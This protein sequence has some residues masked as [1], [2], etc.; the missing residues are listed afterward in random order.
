MDGALP[1]TTAKGTTTCTDNERTQYFLL[2]GDLV[3]Y[4]QLVAHAFEGID[5]YVL[6]ANLLEPRSIGN[7]CPLSMPSCSYSIGVNGAVFGW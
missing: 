4:G 2:K 1:L 6:S 3:H 7:P 5:I